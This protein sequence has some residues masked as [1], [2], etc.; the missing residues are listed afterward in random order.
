M[1]MNCD[2]YICQAD[3][4]SFVKLLQEEPLFTEVFWKDTIDVQ[5]SLHVKK[6]DLDAHDPVL[7]Q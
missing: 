3:L 2:G 5:H 7:Q 6:G 1:D 4:F